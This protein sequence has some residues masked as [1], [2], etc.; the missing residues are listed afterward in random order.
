MK[1]IFF[2][3]FFHKF[4]DDDSETATEDEEE[5]RARELRKQE[6]WLETP[7]RPIDTDT[8]SETEVNLSKS[9]LLNAA[10]LDAISEAS[11]T[12]SN[13]SKSQLSDLSCESKPHSTES[14]EI[15]SVSCKEES[16]I[17]PIVVGGNGGQK[18]NLI[19]PAPDFTDKP[20]NAK[21]MIKV[22]IKF[23]RFDPKESKATVT[24]LQKAMSLRDMFDGSDTDNVK[25]IECVANNSNDNN[26]VIKLE[27]LSAGMS[28]SKVVDVSVNALPKAAVNN[29]IS[30]VK[31]TTC[32]NANSIENSVDPVSQ[33]TPSI[34]KVVAPSVPDNNLNRGIEKTLDTSS[35]MSNQNNNVKTP[36][37]LDSKDSNNVVPQPLMSV[38]SNNL[39]PIAE[40]REKLPDKPKGPV[41]LPL[42]NPTEL[43]LLS[44]IP[45]LLASSPASRASSRKSSLE[46]RPDIYRSLEN[47]DFEFPTAAVEKPK[48]K[49]KRDKS[50]GRRRRKDLSEGSSENSS[51]SAAPHVVVI[52]PSPTLEKPQEKLTLDKKKLTV[53]KEKS[54]VVVVEQQ[55]TS[56]T[57]EDLKR[58]LRE[59]KQR[60]KEQLQELVP[61]SKESA[62][63]KMSEYF[64]KQQTAMAIPDKQSDDSAIKQVELDLKQTISNK[65]EAKDLH[66]YFNNKPS[67]P[68]SSRSNAENR[69]NGDEIEELF[70]DFEK[71]KV[72]L[73]QDEIQSL[74]KD[75]TQMLRVS[76]SQNYNQSYSPRKKSYNLDDDKEYRQLLKKYEAAV[77]D[78]TAK[79]RTSVTRSPSEILATK[80]LKNVTAKTP[81]KSVTTVERSKSTVTPKSFPKSSPPASDK[82]DKS[83]KNKKDKCVVS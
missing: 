8:G 60:N 44:C 42:P 31:P 38:P 23:D 66:K 5:V 45:D 19:P 77:S 81:T 40:S 78:L 71:S 46:S 37:N 62:A 73:S 41:N 16:K 24:D 49:K 80:I 55:P 17:K 30:P 3:F 79:P 58:E 2:C 9:C 75:L 7:H 10:S 14:M 1:A 67:S 74:D 50:V 72:K 69:N 52:A 29:V 34:S 63:L 48:K 61:L 39:S 22:K 6:V 32:E 15:T 20:E 59:R 33:G 11:S 12:G 21:I 51:S 4:T 54:P 25:I 82:F 43:K 68:K 28:N 35:E 65:V 56:R 64:V 27:N 76:A 57:F 83:D 36:E 70:E 53:P 13:L 18:E 26:V 47:L